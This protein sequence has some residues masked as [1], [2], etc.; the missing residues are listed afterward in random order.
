[1]K[2]AFVLIALSVVFHTGHAS[3]PNLKN[4]RTGDVTKVSVSEDANVASGLQDPDQASCDNPTMIGNQEH[5]RYISLRG[6][7]RHHC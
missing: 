6:S 5:G 4:V 2:I 3:R 7:L 1:M